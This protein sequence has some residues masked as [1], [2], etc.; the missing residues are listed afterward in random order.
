MPAPSGYNAKYHDDWGWSLAMKGA[1]DE[2][3]AEAF[4]ISRRTLARWKNDY[5]SFAE[6]LINGKTVADAQVEK[7]LFQR[8]I[9]YDVK[10]SENIVEVDKDG[11]T[12]PVRVRE[13]KKHIP[14]DTMAIMYWLNNRS[15]GTGEWAQSQNIKLSGT[16]NTVDMSGLSED[17][18]R[19]IATLANA[20]E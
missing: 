1:T 2:E 5:P 6:A 10:E 15:K 16:V 19:R 7:K 12:K 4:S 9:G 3:I 17:E 13:T 20:E 14:P 8:A 18:L 11:N